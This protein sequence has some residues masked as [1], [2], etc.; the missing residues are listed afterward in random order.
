MQLIGKAQFISNLICMIEVN[1]AR[2]NTNNL[3][4]ETEAQCPSRTE[5]G[6]FNHGG[7]TDRLGATLRSVSG[8]LM[9]LSS[10][11]TMLANGG[12][13]ARSFCQ[14]SSISWCSASGQSIGAGSLQP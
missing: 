6:G 7:W 3:A 1:H 14:Q 5:S 2:V 11:W 9:R 8:Q 10:V 13:W 12:R 4:S